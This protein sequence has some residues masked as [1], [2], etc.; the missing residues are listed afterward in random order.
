[1]VEIN[2][3]KQF[4]GLI[5]E[6]FEQTFN[7]YCEFEEKTY[8]DDDARLKSPLNYGYIVRVGIDQDGEVVITEDN[9]G[10]IFFFTPKD[11]EEHP[12][13]LDD[14]LYEV[15]DYLGAGEELGMDYDE[16]LELNIDLV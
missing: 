7:S 2:N 5:R 10:F 4:D 12:G 8:D 14:L 1:M 9:S 3:Y 16:W 6:L 11:F 15:Y 13:F